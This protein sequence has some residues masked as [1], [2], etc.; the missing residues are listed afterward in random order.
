MENALIETEWLVVGGGPAGATAAKYLAKSGKNVLLLQRDMQFKKPCG[1]GLRKDAFATFG[2][3]K[4][5]IEFEVE[6][7]DLHYKNRHVSVSLGDN[8]LAIVDRIRFDR[9]L[10]QYAAD[11]GARLEEGRFLFF[12]RL[13]NGFEVTA[14]IGGRRNIIHTR[15][16]IA[17]DGVNS[18]LRKQLTGSTPPAYLTHYADIE[19]RGD[20]QVH[21][22]FGHDIAGS[23][24]AWDFLES[25]GRNIGTLTDAKS[26]ERFYKRL[27]CKVP[28]K[29]KGY[30]IPKY[31]SPLFEH[32][33]V[34][35]VG[36]A[37]GLV[38][39]FTYEGIYYAMASGE[40][41][42]RSIITSEKSESDTY[43]TLWEKA[44]GEKFDTLKRLERFALASDW[45]IALMMTLFKRDSVRR[46]MIALWLEDTKVPKGLRLWKSV[47]RH[48]LNGT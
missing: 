13:E 35:F 16:L 42:S 43:E 48:L 28:T 47:I 39:P 10:R 40:I 3:E 37:A 44:Y 15:G 38:L 29:V 19:D 31:E 4:R 21:F 18:Q 6:S 20:R 33:G 9:T 1:G 32:S 41:L 26:F 22:H 25:G 2:I 7:I 12:K 46:R 23:L 8:R 14:E 5:L 27:K 36:D 30:K 34:Y 45:R 17:A 24:Y 11:A